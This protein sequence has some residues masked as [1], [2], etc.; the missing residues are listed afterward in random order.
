[1]FLA[2]AV[3]LAALLFI[4]GALAS[5]QKRLTARTRT[6]ALP[7]PESATRLAGV[8]QGHID[9][10]IRQALRLFR[11][12]EETYSLVWIVALVILAAAGLVVKRYSLPVGLG[13]VWAG[14]FGLPNL[15]RGAA[16]VR[17]VLVL[18]D[19]PF[20]LLLLDIYLTK[21]P[22]PEAVRA[23]LPSLKGVLRKE[24]AELL[25]DLE[26]RPVVEALMT[27]R[28]RLGVPAAEAAIEALARIQ[29]E[30]GQ[31]ES[32]LAS[33][34]EKLDELAEASALARAKAMPYILVGGQGLVVI[35][36]FLTFALPLFKI[37]LK[38]LT[39]L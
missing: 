39:A 14:V 23:L 32:I 9:P 19:L 13:L 27:F 17:R 8:L 10:D 12:S 25:A 6:A 3:T 16:A 5:D 2:A 11:I 22:L 24:A 21:M 33:Q 31:G 18:R 36:S 38:G 30:G 1:V 28:N 7:I 29:M 20:F 35:A 26:E 15:V 4:P 37:V 34:G